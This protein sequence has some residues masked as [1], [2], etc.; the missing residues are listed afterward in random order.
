ML[1]AVR[2]VERTRA[3]EW[4]CGLSKGEFDR[5]HRVAP[6][7]Q[8]QLLSIRPA[9]SAAFDDPNL[10]S[11]SALALTHSQTPWAH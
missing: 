7:S 6:I 1:T 9:I 11:L 8:I 5:R 3:P 4:G 10:A 2:I